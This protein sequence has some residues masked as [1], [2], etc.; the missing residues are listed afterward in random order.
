M[1]YSLQH[2][3]IVHTRFSY[4]CTYAYIF[5]I[6]CAIASRLQFFIFGCHNLQWFT[7]MLS[8]FA[9]TPHRNAQ[10]QQQ[11]LFFFFFFV[12]LLFSIFAF[13]L[14]HS[15]N[16]LWNFFRFITRKLNYF[17]HS[18]ASSGVAKL[19]HCQHCQHCQLEKCCTTQLPTRLIGRQQVAV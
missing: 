1:L 15:G 14:T 12:I 19:K 5:T 18:P 4:I 6:V 11:Q 17:V 2:I 3:Y 16:T 13:V 9:A 7:F 10:P 8:R